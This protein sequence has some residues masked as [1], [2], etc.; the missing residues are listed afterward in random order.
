MGGCCSA[1]WFK[2][3]FWA[4][5]ALKIAHFWARSI[6]TTYSY[7]LLTNAKKNLFQYMKM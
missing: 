1:V 6:K 3:L 5:P 7:Y 2:K 4:S